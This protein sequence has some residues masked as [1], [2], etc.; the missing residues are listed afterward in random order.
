MK[1]PAWQTLW[2]AC[3]QDMPYTGL[4]KRS[5]SGLNAVSDSL[6]Y[7]WL[8]LGKDA[9]DLTGYESLATGLPT[10]RRLVNGL[11]RY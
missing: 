2:E 6:G 5:S 4:L 3:D 7:V 10:P 9:V 11:P 1:S 8:Q